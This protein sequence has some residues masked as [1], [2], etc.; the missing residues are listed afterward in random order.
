MSYSRKDNKNTDK[1][2]A[3]EDDFDDIIKRREE[4]R[5]QSQTDQDS[6]T[7]LKVLKK[8]SENTISHSESTIINNNLNNYTAIQVD[9]VTFAGGDRKRLRIQEK[10]DQDEVVVMRK[11]NNK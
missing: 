10:T 8:K 2:K 11:G 1:L 3:F 6:N 5:K 4:K 7:F 9:P